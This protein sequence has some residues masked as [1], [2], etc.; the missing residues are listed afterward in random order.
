MSIECNSILNTWVLSIEY[1]RIENWVQF[2]I[3]HMSIEYRV[4]ENW[5][6]NTIQYRVHWTMN[7][8]YISTISYFLIGT[9]LSY[10][11]QN[12]RFLSISKFRSKSVVSKLQRFKFEFKKLPEKI[13]WI[14]SPKHV[15]REIFIA[16]NIPFDS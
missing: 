10:L 6:L 8:I 11:S 3:E 15:C 7:K 5:V 16:R 14:L 4:N 2:S 9:N 1:I 12:W 13:S